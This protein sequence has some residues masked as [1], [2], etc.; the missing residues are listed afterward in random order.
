MSN[1][2]NT[3]DCMAATASG[4]PDEFPPLKNRLQQVLNG[5]NLDAQRAL[6][7]GIATELGTDILDCAAA[8]VYLTQ[9]TAVKEMRRDGS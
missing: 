6:I 5:G 8:L 3:D 1:S 4:S 9:E 2:N 7:K